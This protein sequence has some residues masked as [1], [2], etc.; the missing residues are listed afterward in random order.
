[1]Q[2]NTHGNSKRY[3]IVHVRHPGGKELLEVVKGPLS[4]TEAERALEFERRYSSANLKTFKAVLRQSLDGARVHVPRV[5]PPE[6][7]DEFFERVSS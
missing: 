4:P 2:E 1:M 5:Y 7:F 6:V 3:Y